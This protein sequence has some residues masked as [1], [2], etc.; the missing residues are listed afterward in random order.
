MSLS[1][2]AIRELEKERQA[3]IKA[4]D[5]AVARLEAISLIL[6]HAKEPSQIRRHRKPATNG[7]LPRETAK[8][9]TP[10]AKIRK[11]I[12]RA[13][14]TAALKPGAIIDKL[15]ASGLQIQ[16]KTPYETRVYNELKR[17]VREDLLGRNAERQYVLKV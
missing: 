12:T 8:A 1:D 4:R 3:H 5:E 6:N 9:V 17:M 15:R 13:L 2:H 16:G 10:G 11:A 14:S 7:S